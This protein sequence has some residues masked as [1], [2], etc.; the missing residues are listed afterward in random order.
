V[1][2]AHDLVSGIA[3]RPAWGA[4]YGDHA[5]SEQALG[6]CRNETGNPGR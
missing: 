2:V 5:T 1:L 6:V 4:M 3:L